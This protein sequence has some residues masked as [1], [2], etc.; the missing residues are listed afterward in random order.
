MRK[1]LVIALVVSLFVGIPHVR[2]EQIRPAQV[3]GLFYPD[4]GPILREKIDG[5]LGEVEDQPL[6]G[7]LVALIVPHAGYEFSGK[8]AT[9]A[10]KQLLKRQFN[11]IILIGPSHHRY[12][13]GIS[14]YGEGMFETPLGKIPIDKDLASA[15]IKESEIITFNPE[16]HLKEHSLEVQLPFLQRTSK[17]FKIVPILMGDQSKPFCDI[18]SQT[19]TKVLKKEKKKVLL[20]A[21]TDFSHY[22]PYNEAVK[23]DKIAFSIIQKMDK[24][25]LITGL[26]KGEV[27]M[28]GGGPAA[29]AIEVAKGLRADKIKLLNHANSGDVTKDF[30]RVVGYASFALYSTDQLNKEAQIEL[31][32]IARRSIAEYLETKKSPSFKPISAL[33]KEDRGVFVTLTKDEKLR[34]CIGYT[35]PIK[36]LYEAVRDT[37]IKAATQDLRFPPVTKDELNKIK[38]TISIL[39]PIEE[40][41]DINLIQPGTHGLYITQGWQSGLLLPQVAKERKWSRDEFLKQGCLKAGLPPDAYKKGARIHIFTAQVFDEE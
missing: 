12:F 35:F 10:Y 38:I 5:Y 37:A 17:D 32:K 4:S 6:L 26:A 39:S 40:A 1:S 20:I 22:Y 34:G 28:C 18:L 14:V 30:S 15:I 41:K 8:V 23:K 13:R 3:A 11:T 36:P 21:S 33:I 16:H 9:Y 31:L 24:D 27:E 2:G 7:R 25:E 29:V 19:L